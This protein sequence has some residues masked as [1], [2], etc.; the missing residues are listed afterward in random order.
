MIITKEDYIDVSELSYTE[1]CQLIEERNMTGEDIYESPLNDSYRLNEGNNL[2]KPRTIIES[3]TN[4]LVNGVCGINGKPATMSEPE[5]FQQYIDAAKIL[6]NVYYDFVNS[7]Y[8]EET[9]EYELPMYEGQS[10]TINLRKEMDRVKMIRG[11]DERVVWLYALVSMSRSDIR[12]LLYTEDEDDKG[13]PY[14]KMDKKVAMVAFRKVFRHPVNNIHYPLTVTDVNAFPGRLTIYKNNKQKYSN[15]ALK[16][17]CG[18]GVKDKWKQRPYTCGYDLEYAF[19]LFIIF[20]KVNGARFVKDDYFRVTQAMFSNFIGYRSHTTF[21]QHVTEYATILADPSNI[22]AY[23]EQ[24][25]MLESY[26]LYIEVY[27]AFKNIIVNN[28][29]QM[30]QND[31]ARNLHGCIFLLPALER[32]SYNELAVENV[33]QEIKVTFN[34]D[35][36]TP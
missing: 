30:L 3:F 20:Y 31:G 17:M 14:W 12:E 6:F 4:V 8:D 2:P 23:D 22:N 34:P 33:P 21:K 28:L 35:E 11:A 16:A 15:E 1:I 29:E 32:G 26:S 19:T 27:E 7:T 10:Y 24:Y 13:K 5:Y 36:F 25:G 9:E 18:A